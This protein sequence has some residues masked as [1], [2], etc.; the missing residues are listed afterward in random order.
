[1]KRSTERILTTV[2]GS[3]ARPADL[4]ELMKAKEAGQPFNHE[5]LAIRV[6]SAASI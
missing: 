6:R 4:L 3:L 5:A 1:M 2:V